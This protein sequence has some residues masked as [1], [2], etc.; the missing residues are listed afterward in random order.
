M[1]N[2]GEKTSPAGTNAQNNASKGG[3]DSSSTLQI[4][5]FFD[6]TLNNLSNS[7]IRGGTGSRGNAPTNIAL[8]SEL[9]QHDAEYIDGTGTVATGPDNMMGAGAGTGRTGVSARVHEACRHLANYSQEIRSHIILDVFGFSRGAAAARYFVNCVHRRSFEPVTTGMSI[10]RD[11]REPTSL[12]RIALP[13]ATIRFLGLFDTVAAI[14]TNP[15]DANNEDVNVHLNNSS[16]QTIYHLVAENEYRHNFA[17]NS[18]LSRSGSPPANGIEVSIPGAHADIGGGYMAHIGETLIP[19]APLFEV[20]IPRNEFNTLHNDYLRDWGDFKRKMLLEGKFARSVN[21][22]REGEH[23]ISYQ[24]PSV[25]SCY[26]THVWMRPSICPGLEKIALKLMHSKAQEGSVPFDDLPTSDRYAI[27]ADIAHIYNILRR[28][29]SPSSS[30]LTLLRTKYVH[31]SAYY[32]R[33]DGYNPSA[34]S[35]SDTE[36]HVRTN[37]YPFFPA[38]DLQRIEHRN[39]PNAAFSPT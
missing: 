34:F 11:D 10:S 39:D 30:D 7:G 26:I 14:G 38:T 9:Y 3:S 24:N 2:L 15:S 18:I 19:I 8:L 28:G 31:W 36:R 25:A 27:P 5:F 1:V 6:G 4:G 29:E 33:V 12:S 22:F 21:E 32:D 13:S 20:N 35:A 37:I 23:N 16:A 17:L